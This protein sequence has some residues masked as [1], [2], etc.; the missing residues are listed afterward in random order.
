MATKAV[1]TKVGLTKVAG[2]ADRPWRMLI[3]GE[4]VIG[5]TGETMPVV[6]PG[7]ESVIAQIP[8]GDAGDVDDSVKAAGAAARAMAPCLEEIESY[9]QQRM[10]TLDS[11]GTAQAHDADI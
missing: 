4:L 7:D 2:Y 11:R 5:R 8:L 6:H 9:T 1:L 10:S 3:G